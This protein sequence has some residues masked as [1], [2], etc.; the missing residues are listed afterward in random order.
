MP[1]GKWQCVATHSSN[2]EVKNTQRIIELAA[3]VSL[4]PGAGGN[5]V[6]SPAF[7]TIIRFDFRLEGVQCTV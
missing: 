1:D 4:G 7:V 6:P 5:C 2:I 3:A